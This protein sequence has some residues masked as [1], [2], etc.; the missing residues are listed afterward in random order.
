MKKIVLL[1]TLSFVLIS[2]S[3]QTY[4][5]KRVQSPA[6]KLN[7]EYCSNLFK[8]VD[9]TI[10]N[11][12]MDASARSY[13]NILDWMQGRVAGLQVY[14]QKDGTPVAYIRNSRASIYLDE[15]PVSPETLSAISS[16]NIAIIKVVKTAFVG[17]PGNGGGGVIA[18]YTFKGDDDID[19]S[20][21]DGQP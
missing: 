21:D 15:I 11:V 10:L 8:D 5:G 1:A 3:A 20:G 18:V 4:V 19:E 2:A 14:H 17:A 12:G 6:E 7:N 13:L 16:A 9:G